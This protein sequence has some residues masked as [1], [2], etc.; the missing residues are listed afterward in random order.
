VLSSG[1]V[2]GAREGYDVIS[3]GH[4]LEVG[5]LPAD[6]AQ[7]LWGVGSLGHVPPRSLLQKVC[8][9]V[10]VR[11]RMRV[12]VCVCVCV[13]VHVCVR[14]C[15]CVCACASVRMCMCVCLCVFDI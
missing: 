3:R 10:C 4:G 9:C 7:L 12:C 11:V 2:Q 6:Y 1:G 8:R 5:W 13:C 14:A 15:A